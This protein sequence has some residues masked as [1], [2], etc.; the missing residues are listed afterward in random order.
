[1][2]HVMF[3]NVRS[4]HNSARLWS[5]LAD[6]YVEVSGYDKWRAKCHKEYRKAKERY[7]W[8]LQ[9]IR[10]EREWKSRHE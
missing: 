8:Y 10:R 7:R 2:S 3:A 1:M 4:A 6:E 5:R 9:L